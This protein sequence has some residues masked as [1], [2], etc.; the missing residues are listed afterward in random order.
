MSFALLPGYGWIDFITHNLM[1]VSVVLFYKQYLSRNW[2][3]PFSDNK[4][5]N[6]ISLAGTTQWFNQCIDAAFQSNMPCLTH[7]AL[8]KNNNWF[9]NVVSKFIIQMKSERFSLRLWSY[10]SQVVL[11]AIRQYCQIQYILRIKHMG[12]QNIGKIYTDLT[13][14]FIWASQSNQMFT[15]PLFQIEVH[16]LNTVLLWGFQSSP[17]PFSL[18]KLHY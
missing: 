6:L 2:V 7:Q 4:H 8:D 17:C 16:L 9:K 18:I 1:H 3:T 10:I 15:G 12:C 11:L 5:I 13:L 14:K